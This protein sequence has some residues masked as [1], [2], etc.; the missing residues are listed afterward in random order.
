[1][2]LGKLQEIVRDGEAWHDAVHGVTE[3]DMSWR[4]NSSLYIYTYIYM[5]SVGLVTKSCQTLCNPMDYSLLGSSVH[6]I[7]P[8]NVLEWVTIP[9]SKGSSLRDLDSIPG[10]ERSLGEGN[11]NP[12]QYVWWGN[13]IYI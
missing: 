10:S 3:S 13:P 8:Q 7:S 5:L 2:K 9:F 11:G 1:M 4:L 6:G 12:L